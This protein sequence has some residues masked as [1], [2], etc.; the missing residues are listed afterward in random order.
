[1]SLKYNVQLDKPLYPWVLNYLSAVFHRNY[2]SIKIGFAFIQWSL[3]S[4]AHCT[5]LLLA[6]VTSER[7]RS[8]CTNRIHLLSRAK[9]V[10]WCSS[11]LSP[12]A[13][14]FHNPHN[15]LGR[16]IQWHELTYHLYADDAKHCM[17]FKQSDVTSKYDDICRIKAC[18]ADIQI[19]MNDDFLKLNDDKTEFLIITTREE[20]SKTSD[21]SIKVGDQSISPIDDPPR[22]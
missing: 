17:A 2:Y 15:P 11:R 1:M 13:S 19:W 9:S 14:T 20:L 16:I 7:Q 6:C 12:G 18:V 5:K 10:I 8:I 22:N 3:D 21:M 4:K